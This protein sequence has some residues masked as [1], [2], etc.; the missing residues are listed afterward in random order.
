MIIKKSTTH[1]LKKE[2]KKF[3][4]SFKVFTESIFLDT[5]IWPF[6]KVWFTG[7]DTIVV[8]PSG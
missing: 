7:M 5:F 4:Q 1:S 6:D 8:C 3:L 2:V